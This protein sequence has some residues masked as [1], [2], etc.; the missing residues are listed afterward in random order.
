ML[1]IL[2]QEKRKKC[3]FPKNAE[4]NANI[5]EKGLVRSVKYT[6]KVFAHKVLNGIPTLQKRTLQ[7]LYRH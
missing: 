1:A 4:K 3:S 7:K 5:I 6:V 2:F